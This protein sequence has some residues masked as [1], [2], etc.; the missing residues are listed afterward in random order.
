MEGKC[1]NF[2]DNPVQRLGDFL[3]KGQSGQDACQFGVLIQRN[4]MLP[5]DADDFLRQFVGAGCADGGGF[6]AIVFECDGGP[7]VC[8]L[9]F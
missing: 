1:Q 3:V 7:G 8:V 6:V 4:V 2:G 9:C 5:G